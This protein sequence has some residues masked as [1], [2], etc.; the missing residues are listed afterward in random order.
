MVEGTGVVLAGFDH[1]STGHWERVLLC[2]AG[3]SIAGLLVT[4]L[5]GRSVTSDDPSLKQ[6]LHADH[7]G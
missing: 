7:A 4:R 3:F 5:T 6:H 1:V 2:L